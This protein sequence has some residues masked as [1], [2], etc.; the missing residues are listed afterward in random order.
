MRIFDLDTG[1]V[2]Y[3]TEL[4]AGRVSSTKRYYIRFRIDVWQQG[5][6]VFTHEY[7]AEGERILC[8]TV[9]GRHARRHARLVSLCRE[10]CGK[11]QMPPDLRDG[12]PADPAVS[13]H[14]HPDIEFVPGM[15]R[16]SLSNTT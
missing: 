16:S 1:N 9:P 6:S 2:L 12:G 11:A 14:P 5:E 3:E 4:K 8:S 10:I 15:A 7:S 13:R